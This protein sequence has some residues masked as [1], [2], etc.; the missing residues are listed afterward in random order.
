MMDNDILSVIHETAKGLTDANVMDEQTLHE[1]DALCI[2]ESELEPEL[3]K[4]PPA[5][6]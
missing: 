3:T 4:A 1:F 6:A 5:Q 2:P